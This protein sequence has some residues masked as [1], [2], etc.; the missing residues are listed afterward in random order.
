MVSKGCCGFDN[1]IM[2]AE[3]YGTNIIYNS[4][5]FA[6]RIIN[7]TVYKNKKCLFLCSKSFIVSLVE[8]RSPVYVRWYHIGHTLGRSK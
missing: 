6:R 8:Y 2:R 3:R 4:R 1:H 7:N 5:V